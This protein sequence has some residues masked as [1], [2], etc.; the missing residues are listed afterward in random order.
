[1]KAIRIPLQPHSHFHFGEF[2]VDSNVALSSTSAFAHSDMLFSALVN[3][4]QSGVGEADGFVNDFKTGEIKIS[5]MFYYLKKDNEIV[6]LLPKPVFLDLY[7]PR[8]GNHKLRNRIK[9]VSAGVWQQGFNTKN[10]TNKESDFAFIQNHDILLTKI[11]CSALG[12]ATSDV[13][14]SIVDIPKSPIR[15]NNPD[16]SIYYQADVETG[17]LKG[18]EIGFYFLYDATGESENRLKQAINIM[19]YSGFGGERNNTGRAMQEPV[20]DETLNMV[21]NEKATKGFTNLS[22]LNPANS[23]ELNKVTYSQSI[24]R[25]GRKNGK[26]KYEYK[27]VR[28]IREGALLAND[29]ISGRLVEIGSDLEEHTA[30]RNGMAFI[31][32]LTYFESNE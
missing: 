14:F 13:V 24:L 32:P 1:M 2:K 28:M 23:D 25:G 31:I 26:E 10:W 21:L 7:S 5:S 16:D 3:S 29:E 12:I 18:V 17:N 15:K 6:F 20:F 4:F 27:V 22:L 30:Y 9:F 11:E 8:D 19:V